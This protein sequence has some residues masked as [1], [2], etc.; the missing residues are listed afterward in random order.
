MYVPRT[1]ANRWVRYSNSNKN[2]FAEYIKKKVKQKT[3][4]KDK[5]QINSKTEKRAQSR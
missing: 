4:S 2:C 5:Y 1:W 3:K